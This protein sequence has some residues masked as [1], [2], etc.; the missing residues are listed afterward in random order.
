M[1]AYLTKFD[2][3]SPL[4]AIIFDMSA[5]WKSSAAEETLTG[6][7]VCLPKVFTNPPPTA[8]AASPLHDAPLPLDTHKQTHVP[9]YNFFLSPLL[10]AY[11]FFFLFYVPSFNRL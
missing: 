8:L 7:L 4:Q 9:F 11:D 3:I 5:L 2:H 10:A 6:R 1:D